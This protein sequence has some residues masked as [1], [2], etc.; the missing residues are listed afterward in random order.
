MT[1]EQRLARTFVDLADSLVDRFDVVDLLTLLTERCVELLDVSAAGLLLGDG[2]GALRLMAATSEAVELVELFQ[3]QSDEGPCLDCYRTGDLVVVPDLCEATGRWPRF[4]PVALDGG[5]HTVHAFPLRLRKDVLGALGLF[6][7]SPGG[8][9]A[10]ADEVAQAL[11]DVAT[12]ALIQHRA[13][14]D[15]HLLAEQLQVALNSRIAIEQAKGVIAERAG[16]EMEDAF[17]LLRR[18]SRSRQRL[19]AE[20]AQEVAEGRLPASA[21]MAP[22][23]T[24]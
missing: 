7:A 2:T 21:L 15:T 9:D 17:R 3:I 20:V 11:A 8:P 16:I 10:E 19:L 14:D 24:A 4:A 12:I 1:R 18:Y 13:I 5:F 22:P 23:P 6:G